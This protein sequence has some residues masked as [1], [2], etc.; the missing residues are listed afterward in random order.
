V[1]AF[2]L[3]YMT[4]ADSLMSRPFN[5][6]NVGVDSNRLFERDQTYDTLAHEPPFTEQPFRYAA[7]P[8]EWETVA[9]DG[10]SIYS[11]TTSFTFAVATNGSLI[12][13]PFPL[14]SRIAA[15]GFAVPVAIVGVTLTY[16]IRNATNTGMI[17]VYVAIDDRPQISAASSASIL[18]QTLTPPGTAE[19]TWSDVRNNSFSL[20]VA[21][22][23]NAGQSVSIYASCANQATDLIWASATIKYVVL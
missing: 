21:P 11:P 17:G 4:N 9:A 6:V 3:K 1:G 23:V 7:P 12:N 16:A 5:I 2:L 22:L 15:Q 14:A 18:V 8:V 20:D 19:Q 10:V 13:A